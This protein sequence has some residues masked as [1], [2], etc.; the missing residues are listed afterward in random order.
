MPWQQAESDGHW[1]GLGRSVPKSSRDVQAVKG[2][3][4]GVGLSETEHKHS[5]GRRCL[6]RLSAQA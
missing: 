3:A 4:G 6:V 2:S 5:F 1:V